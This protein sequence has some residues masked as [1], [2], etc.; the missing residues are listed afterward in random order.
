M[1]ICNGN[2]PTAFDILMWKKKPLKIVYSTPSVDFVFPTGLLVVTE[3][4]QQLGRR[5]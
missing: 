4:K 1:E 2:S 5:Q 3:E